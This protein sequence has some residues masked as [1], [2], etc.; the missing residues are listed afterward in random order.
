[1][2]QITSGRLASVA[3]RFPMSTPTPAPFPRLRLIGE[4]VCIHGAG[5]VLVLEH[6]DAL[7]LA[8]LAIE[9]PTPRR[10]LAMLLWPD[11]DSERARANLRQRLFRL[12][13][14]LGFNLLEGAAV[15]SLPAHVQVDLATP[16]AGAPELLNA[17]TEADA[18]G[19]AAWL[20]S[21]RQR[22][23]AQHIESLA[24][25]AARLESAGELGQALAV[26]QQLLACDPTSEQAHRRVVRLHYLRGDRSAALLAFDRCEQVLKDDVGA[27]PSAE[28][29]ALLQTVEQAKAPAWTRGQPLPVSV[30]KPPRM[31]GREA[32]SL[33]AGHAWLAGEAFVVTGDAGVGKS[34]LLAELFD[35]RADVLVLRAR[36]GDDA[37]PLSTLARLA[38]ALAEHWPAT[39]AGTAY[40]ALLKLASGSG[41]DPHGAIRS[42]VPLGADLLRAAHAGGLSGVVLDDLQ[43]ADEASFDTWREWL[44]AAALAGL[45]FGFACRVEGD[46]AQVRIERLRQRADTVV[47]GVPPLAAA[48][49]RSLVE[50]L[51]LA[52]T[53]VPAVAAA[54]AQRIGGNPLHLLET[55]RRALEHCG[56]LLAD[57][58]DTPTQVL[59]L[60]EQRLRALNPEGLLLVRIAAVAGSDF[61]PELAQAVSRRDVL[62]LADAWSALERQGILDERGFAH[63]LMLDAAMRLLPLPI[64]RV[65]HRRVAEYIGSRGAPPARLAHHWLRADEPLEALAPLVAAARLAWRA[66]RGR[67]TS[68]AFFKAADIEVG[69]GQP[70]AAFDLLFESA[71]AM[72]RLSPVAAFDTVI[73][74]IVPLC[75]TASHQARMALLDA[76]SKY[77]HG[78]HAGSTRGMADAQLLAIA[79][80]DG[81]VE[82][83]CLY[84][85]AYR[86]F[87][88]GRLRDAVEQMSACAALQRSLGLERLALV[89]DASKLVVLRMLGQVRPVLDEQQRGL[90]WLVDHGDPVDLATA[91][92]EQVLSRLDLGD[93]GAADG[94]AQQAWQ[95]IRDTDMGGEE[96][97]RNASAMLRF[98]RRR[99]RWDRALGIS[100]EAAQ[101]LT[102]QGENANQLASERAD[103][104]LDLGRPELAR[105]YIE[106]LESESAHLAHSR[107]SSMALRWRYECATGAAVVP[108]QT[109]E[110]VLR[111]EQFLMACELVLVAGQAWPPQLS[112]APLAPL[113]QG[114]EARELHGYLLP[115]RAL[116]A[117]LLARDGGLEAASFSALG[118]QAALAR[119]DLGAA[120]PACALWTAKALECVGRPAAAAAVTRQASAWL[121]QRLSESVPAEFHAS[122]RLRNPVHRELLALAQRLGR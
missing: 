53:D 25:V 46:V 42:A 45:H 85:K 38:Q 87:A 3:T 91:R 11:V 39:L 95:A 73:A 77:L 93:V 98:H 57:R 105:P 65:I 26:A 83:E 18:G 37:A 36:P 41:L 116:Q 52:G 86:S 113:I 8:Y 44:D 55:I 76:G 4:P 75:R 12:R 54:L 58:L 31:I 71:E 17:I 102:A 16:G 66:G 48:Q 78:D 9:G 81:F 35:A 90:P 23:R 111:S 79:C 32:E 84:D 15:A 89:T 7:M 22:H 56:R 24:G 82:A 103:L 112:A 43:F 72:A 96:L 60:L 110:D 119:A 2:L 104:Y 51:A 94:A 69:R 30:L 28:T 59:D 67:E 70:D 64:R 10:A 92:V 99:G 100:D 6:K 74:R 121:G 80:G 117:W 21:T 29:L 47:I 115:L 114:C 13:K 49:T 62:E 107:W 106:T 19:L 1:M 63:D 14:A 109:L 120:L 101:R 20:A 61:S 122:F 33:A 34:R 27:R 5:Q 108:L 118:T 50:S 88:E 68:E 40:A 97:C